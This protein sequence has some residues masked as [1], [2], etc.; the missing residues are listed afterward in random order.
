MKA[1]GGR[2]KAEEVYEEGPDLSECESCGAGINGCDVHYAECSQCGR[3]GC[4]RCIHDGGDD[5]F[6][7]L[8]GEC[9]PDPD[10]ENTPEELL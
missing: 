2:M 4:T 6:P 3:P 1:E 8:C 9:D 7:K 10:P 5:C